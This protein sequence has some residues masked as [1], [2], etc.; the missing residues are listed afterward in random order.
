MQLN[1]SI[2]GSISSEHIRLPQ[3]TIWSLPEKVLQFGT[4]VLLR[5]L[6]DFFIDKA[7]NLNKFNG[8]IVV[9][10][11]T[12]K[13]DADLFSSQDN[14]YTICIRGIEQNNQVEENIVNASISRVLNAKTEWNTIL[15]CASS[16]DLQIIVSNTTEAGIVPDMEMISDEKA[17]RTFPAKLLAFLFKRFEVFQGSRASGLIIIPTELISDNGKKLKEILLEL[18]KYNRLNPKF[19]EWLNLDNKFCSSLVDRIVPGYPSLE[20][21]HQIEDKLGYH[22]KLMLMAEPFCLWAIEGDDSVREKLSFASVDTGVIITPDITR[23]KELKLRLLNGT[24]SLLCGLAHA[25]G[26]ALVRESMNDD[27]F[28]NFANRLVMNE[29]VPSIPYDIDSSQKIEFASKVFDRFRNPTI[30]HKWLSISVQYTAKIKMRVV[31]LLLKFVELYKIIPPY[32]TAGLAGF[33]HFM[34]PI[35]KENGKYFGSSNGIEYE[36]SD[37]QAEYFYQAWSSGLSRAK[38]IQNI[39]SNVELW[40]VD[41]SQ[42]T[43]LQQSVLHLLENI[44][45]YPNRD[46]LNSL[47]EK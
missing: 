34:R 16:T 42:I 19:V 37:D 13:G 21:I 5:G 22:D 11:S 45:Q 4:G 18:A 40:G 29:I 9:V 7:N 10:K 20:Q 27:G 39:L 44:S 23:F 15:D 31:P 25:S 32:M 46:L 2:L 12:D 38:V 17:P 33:I 6:P 35:K 14:L 43:G 36:I 1:K 28:L 26:F 47:L 30:D 3:A 8:R 41:L 24:H